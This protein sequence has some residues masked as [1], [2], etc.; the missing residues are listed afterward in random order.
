VS[1]TAQFVLAGLFT[2]VT[3]GVMLGGAQAPWETTVRSGE[4]IETDG[5]SFRFPEERRV[6]NAGGTFY[7]GPVPLLATLAILASIGGLIAGGAL[8]IALYFVVVVGA[9][10]ILGL[11]MQTVAYDGPA[12]IE[13]TFGPGQV[14][15]V[16]GAV[17]T[18]LGAI[19]ALLTGRTVPRLSMPESAP[20]D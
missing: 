3:S 6:V 4:L 14:I 17:G 7:A 16:G 1:P 20:T 15:T 2:I 10:W 12:G 19:T 5:Q 8:R 13:R 18:L 9:V 11:T